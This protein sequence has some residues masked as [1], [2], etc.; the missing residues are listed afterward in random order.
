MQRSGCKA[1]R[2]PCCGRSTW[3]AGAPEPAKSVTRGRG[4][5]A[6]HPWP[7]SVGFAVSTGWLARMDTE[8][9]APSGRSRATRALGA[10]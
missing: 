9:A 5:S 10:R 8:F 4:V 1:E 7:G 2:S 3:C 6:E